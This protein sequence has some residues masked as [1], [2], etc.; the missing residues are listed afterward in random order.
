[1]S[2]C[3]WF[4]YWEPKPHPQYISKVF[5]QLDF[6]QAASVM[7]VMKDSHERQPWKTAMKDSHERQPGRTARMCTPIVWGI[8]A[9]FHSNI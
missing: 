8:A 5:L 9:V 3:I 4:D 7:T 6:W 2:Y 1:M